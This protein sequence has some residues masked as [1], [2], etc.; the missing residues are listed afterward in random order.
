[1]EVCYNCGMNSV[2]ISRIRYKKSSDFLLINLG[3]KKTQDSLPS[4]EGQKQQYMPVIL[5]K[6]AKFTMVASDKLNR[7]LQQLMLSTSGLL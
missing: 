4:L 1:M 7:W 5:R 6:Q 2:R 3:N